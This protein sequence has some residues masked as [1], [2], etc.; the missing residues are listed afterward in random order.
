MKQ[1][2]RASCVLTN[3]AYLRLFSS[4]KWPGFVDL[5]QIYSKLISLYDME[6]N[7]PNDKVD[8][9]KFPILFCQMYSVHIAKHMVMMKPT[10]EFLDW[11]AKGF[12][13]RKLTKKEIEAI[14]RDVRGTNIMATHQKIAFLNSSTHMYRKDYHRISYFTRTGGV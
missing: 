7:H 10:V 3:P 12:M 14:M 5:Q 9:K 4:D 11:F 2:L 6:K 13:Q 8:L 1:L